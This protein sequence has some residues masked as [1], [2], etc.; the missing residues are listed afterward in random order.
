MVG[1]VRAGR[2]NDIEA[3]CHRIVEEERK[4]GHAHVAAIQFPDS[5]Q[6][7]ARVN[8]R[9]W[10]DIIQNLPNLFEVSLPDDVEQPFPPSGLGDEEPP[11]AVS[12]SDANAPAVCVI[13]SGI[14]EGHIWLEPAIDTAVSRCFLPDRN[15]TDVNDEVT[16]GGHGTRVGGAVLYPREVPRRGVLSQSLFCKMPVF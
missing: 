9:G 6:I 11:P 4:R 14:Q 1:F 3:L 13:D 2:S 7:R 15:R 10:R 5:I 16:S 12:A 8:G